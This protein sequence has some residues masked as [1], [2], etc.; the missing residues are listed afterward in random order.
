VHNAHNDRLGLGHAKIDILAA[1]NREA[2]ASTNVVARDAGVPQEGDALQMS[3]EP[4]NEA[5]GRHGIAS[6]SHTVID[7]IEVI[8]RSTRDVQRLCLDRASPRAR[9]SAVNSAALA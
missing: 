5:P 6:R 9:M 3:I 2:K 1:V 8:S 4:G 7:C